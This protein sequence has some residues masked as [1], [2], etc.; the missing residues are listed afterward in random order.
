M[1]KTTKILIPVLIALVVLGAIGAWDR[2]STGKLS[3][4]F[5]SYIPWG[6]WVGL[7]I[8][9]VGLSGG[10]FLIVFL[11]YALGIRALRR[12]SVY[13][14]LV[15]LT[16]LGAGLVLVLADLGHMDRFWRLY[17]FANPRSILAWMVWI[18]TLYALVL[19]AMLYAL[20]KE[21]RGWLKPLSVV[22]FILVITFGG[23]E[24]ALFGVLGSKAAWSSG[25][26]PIRFLFSAFLSGAGIVA[27]S[28]V[29][30]RRWQADQEHHRQVEFLRY[31][32]LG[33][34]ALN[35]YIE[36]AEFLVTSYSST[37]AIVETY[38]L[39]LFGSYWWLF[40]LVQIG[41]G[42]V[43]PI[44]LLVPPCDGKPANLGT[45]GLFIAIGLAGTKQNFVYLGLAIP[46]FRALPEAFVHA[47]LSVVYFPSLT[48]WLV[49][50]GVVAAAALVFLIAIE[51]LP[52][53][54]GR[55]A[56]PGEASSVRLEPLREGGG[57]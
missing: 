29:A 45:A 5:G 47:R 26:Q 40:W 16:T 8:Y 10:A 18:Y 27:F 42:L 38:D 6:I 21:K 24:G 17:A 52:F 44:L 49:A 12:A 55:R 36:S 57:A 22:G 9:L 15:A 37:A 31:L 23:G 19:M 3:F 41:I 43:L 25:I 20:A 50:I 39:M 54:D 30:F 33:L 32:V 35:L 28:T 4:N 46:E 56:P 13:A 11:H 34:L 7:Y 1:L 53:V 2:L 51:K 14:L 48:E